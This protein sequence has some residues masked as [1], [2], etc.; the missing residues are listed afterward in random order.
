[1]NA[2][3]IIITMKPHDYQL[4]LIFSFVIIAFVCGEEF[5]ALVS[6]SQKWFER[7]KQEADEFEFPKNAR[8]YEAKNKNIEGN[9]IR[10]MVSIIFNAWST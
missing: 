1:M 8:M 7:R 9:I 2:F 3:Q 4:N 10:I 5:Q 6:R